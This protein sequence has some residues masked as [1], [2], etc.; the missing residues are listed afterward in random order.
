[1]LDLITEGLK[2]AAQK[3]L[4]KVSEYQKIVA[5]NEELA[6][7]LLQLR[8]TVLAGKA[9]NLVVD[10][11]GLADGFFNKGIKTLFPWKPELGRVNNAAKIEYAI[12]VTLLALDARQ[13]LAATGHKIA[14]VKSLFAIIENMDLSRVPK[15][16]LAD[17][18]G[19]L[20]A[21]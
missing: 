2:S 9:L 13:R 7:M 21:K 8:F 20:K 14:E 17:A 5:Q 11:D 6:V 18:L 16:P 3:D 19:A 4:A 1:M 10:L 12:K 15:G